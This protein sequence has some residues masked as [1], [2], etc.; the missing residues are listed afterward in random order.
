DFVTA[1]LFELAKTL[2]RKKKPLLDTGKASL[3]TFTEGLCVQCMHIGPFDDEPATLEMMKRFI[4][5]N[6]LVCDLS[7]TRRHHEIYFSDP[8]KVDISKMK[9]ILR[10]PVRRKDH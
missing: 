9:T 4:A 3:I 6:G 8:R 2:V 5:D 1:D 7:E 10:Y